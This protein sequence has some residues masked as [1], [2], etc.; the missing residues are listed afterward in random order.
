[1]EQKYKEGT[2]NYCCRPFRNL[3]KLE[4]SGGHE[5]CPDCVLN[6]VK[7]TRIKKGLVDRF[8]QTD[9]IKCPECYEITIMTKE[10]MK[11]AKIVQT[12][13]QIKDKMKE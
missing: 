2:C 10:F 13:L 5:F 11:E 1:M 9:A 7:I 12:T 8:T 4:C 6:L 3:M